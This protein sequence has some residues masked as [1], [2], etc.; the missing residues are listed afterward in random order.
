MGQLFHIST[1][2]LD[3]LRNNVDKDIDKYKKMDGFKA[4]CDDIRWNVK[5]PVDVDVERLHEITHDFK[6][7]ASESDY[8]NSLIVGR[9]LKN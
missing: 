7:S 2:V 6:K 8:E 9:H 3:N 1:A 4:L 5:L